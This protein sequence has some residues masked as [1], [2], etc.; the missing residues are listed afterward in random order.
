MREAIKV[1]FPMIGNTIARKDVHKLTY[2]AW[3]LIRILVTEHIASLQTTQYSQQV[4]RAL[5]HLHL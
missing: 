1:S 5:A 4:L 2:R 3:Y